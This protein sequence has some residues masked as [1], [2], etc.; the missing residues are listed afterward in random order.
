M[1]VHNIKLITPSFESTLVDTLFELN[2]VR[3]LQLGGV[4]LS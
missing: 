1:N 4:N 3:K 2:H